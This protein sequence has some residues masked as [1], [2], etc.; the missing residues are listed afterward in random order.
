M[1]RLTAL[2][3]ALALLLTAC[4][5][6]GG[7]DDASTGGGDVTFDDLVGNS[8]V[9]SSV[10]GQE[11]V[12]GSEIT[13]TFI[14][15]RVSALAGCNTQNGSAD[16]EDGKLVVGQL[17]STMMACEDALMAQDQWLAGFLEA[18]PEIA[19]ADGTLTLTSDD[20]VLELTEQ[21]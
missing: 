18:S 8:Y 15:G 7:D 10:T 13:L 16:V 14:D 20:V 17:A 5:D 6:D 4:G 19:L 21:S 9:S 12:D 1:G 11:L 2:F 3:L